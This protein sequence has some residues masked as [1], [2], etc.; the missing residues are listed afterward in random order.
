M[1]GLWV[2]EW[3]KNVPS[4]SPLLF[5]KGFYNS[6][7]KVSPIDLFL[8]TRNLDFSPSK[9]P[10]VLLSFSLPLFLSL[11][12]TPLL[13]LLMTLPLL[14]EIGFG[15]KYTGYILVLPK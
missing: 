6:L 7:K 2:A 4:I 1:L 11:T 10:L 9:M 14:S 13:K 15:M 3:H 12:H 5:L 8:T